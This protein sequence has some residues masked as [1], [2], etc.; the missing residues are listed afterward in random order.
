MWPIGVP[1][2]IVVN[3]TPEK[4]WVR[5]G[6]LPDHPNSRAPQFDMRD[7][8]DFRVPM[9]KNQRFDIQQKEI[10]DLEIDSK[11]YYCRVRLAA[12][13]WCDRV[14]RPQHDVTVN[15][16]VRKCSRAQQPFGDALGIS[17]LQVEPVT[18]HQW[19]QL[20]AISLMLIVV[21]ELHKYWHQRTV[22]KNQRQL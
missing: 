13:Q 2:G 17:P 14:G 21:D 10:R 9:P 12:E 18:L 1:D 7:G 6:I 3:V 8:S 19:M 4:I 22:Q 16:A 5:E 15:G 11:I 20:L